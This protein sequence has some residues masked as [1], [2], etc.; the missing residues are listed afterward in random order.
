MFDEPINQQDIQFSVIVRG[1]L[2]PY[3]VQIPKCNTQILWLPSPGVQVWIFKNGCWLWGG[4]KSAMAIFHN[5]VSSIKKQQL[6]YG[7][8]RVKKG[9]VLRF[10]SYYY[11]KWSHE[12]LEVFGC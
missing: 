4:N 7:L 1:L 9:L 3:Y 6:P 5:F 11:Q 2:Q 8:R 10:G 12:L